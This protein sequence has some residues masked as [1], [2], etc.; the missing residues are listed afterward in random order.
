MH[1]LE[2]NVMK[3]ESEQSRLGDIIGSNAYGDVIL[4]HRTKDDI[5]L[6]KYIHL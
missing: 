4:R 2:F 3:F 5:E 6:E 1:L